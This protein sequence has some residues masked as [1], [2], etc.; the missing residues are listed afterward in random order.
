MHDDPSTTIVLLSLT[1]G[2]KESSFSV[3]AN[4][5]VGHG[6]FFIFDDTRI[7]SNC[8]A[9]FYDK[10]NSTMIGACAITLRPTCNVSN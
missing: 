1:I 6:P 7:L 4:E 8:D 10:I 9:Y 2:V 3:N 5:I